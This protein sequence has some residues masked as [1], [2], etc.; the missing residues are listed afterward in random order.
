MNQKGNQSENDLSPFGVPQYS[1]LKENLVLS[2]VLFSTEVITSNPFLFTPQLNK[3]SEPRFCAAEE[4]WSQENLEDEVDVEEEKLASP[5]H[6][7]GQDFCRD[8]TMYFSRI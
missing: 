3:N 6:V 5:D 7:T 1:G 2:L 8:L 4:Y